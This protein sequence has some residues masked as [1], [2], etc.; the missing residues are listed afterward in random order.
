MVGRTEEQG[1]FKEIMYGMLGWSSN[2]G[3]KAADKNVTPEG[4]KLELTDSEEALAV[5]SNALDS[6]VYQRFC[7]KAQLAE[8]R[9]V[10]P[11]CELTTS[12]AGIAHS[13]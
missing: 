2:D 11:L 12:G 3:S 5:S 9:V 13:Q 6:H 4:Q 10:K 7:G 8:R 1:R